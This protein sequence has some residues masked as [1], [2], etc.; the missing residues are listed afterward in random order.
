VISALANNQNRGDAGA[1]EAP[2]CA[3][4]QSTTFTLRQAT[5]NTETLVILERILEALSLDLALRTNL[6]GISG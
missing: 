1:H 5:P 2:L 4:A 3:S 6:F